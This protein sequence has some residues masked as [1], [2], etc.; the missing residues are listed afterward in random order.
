[1]SFRRSFERKLTRARRHRGKTGLINLLT[2]IEEMRRRAGRTGQ[3]SHHR[4]YAST[5][6]AVEISKGARL[7]LV[8][9]SLQRH[10]TWR[11]GT[12]RAHAQEFLRAIDEQLTRKVAFA[13]PNSRRP[14]FKRRV[15]SL[16]ASPNI[17]RALP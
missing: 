5:K 9:C 10:Y 14:H 2:D 7:E 4:Q 15:C 11:K 12:R 6:E 1:M 13:S 8:A 16:A 3:G 17:K